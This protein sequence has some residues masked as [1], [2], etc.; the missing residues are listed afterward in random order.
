M[1]SLNARSNVLIRKFYNCTTEVKLRLFQSYCL[2]SYCS[3]LW[4]NYAK[5]TYSKLRVAFNKMYKRI[6]GLKKFDSAS[7]MYVT[8]DI[9]NFDAF[10]RKNIY[11]FM[12]RVCNIHND[13]VKSIVFGTMHMC[14]SMWQ[15]WALKLHTCTRL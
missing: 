5:H 9:D 15:K 1:R 7:H 11:G 2:P 6:L 12:N 10:M 13:L 14:N 4:V 3:H 8:N